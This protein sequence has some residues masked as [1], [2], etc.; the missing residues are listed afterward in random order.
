MFELI[1]GT[2][3]NI[4]FNNHI[5]ENFKNFF[6]V[7]NYVYNGAGVAVGDVNNDG[8]SDIYF[9]GNEVSNKLYLNQGDFNFE[10][11]SESAGVSGGEG[12]HN[13]VVMADVN[14]DG[15]QDIYVCR[16]GSNDSD[17][18][19]ANLLFVNQGDTTFKEQA[20]EYGLDDSGYSLMAS[21]FDMDNDNDLDLYVTNRPNTFFMGYQQVLQGK[22]KE[23]DLF[24]DKLYIN[25]NGKFKEV[26]KES[27]IKNN[28]GYGLGIAT[29]DLD[30][31]G[32]TD[33]MVSNDYL[34]RDYL[35][36]NQ[37]NGKFKDELP[38]HFNHV[39]FYAMGIDVV[40]FNND[41]FEDIMQLE[42]LPEDY[43]RSKT[44]MASMNMQLF[45]DMTE[46]GFHYQYMHNQLHLNQGNGIFSD[47]S[48]YSG[49]SKTDWSWA[50]L[51]SDF[52]NDGYRDLFITNGFKRDI[53]DKDAN[54][55]F[56]AYMRSPKSRGKT[57]EQK[58][59][60]II[61]LFKENKIPNYIYKNNGDL[62]FSKKIV[63][64]GMDHDSFSSGAATADFDNDG[65][66]DIA[67]NNIDGEAF[68]YRNT[69]EKLNNN[70]IKLKL[71]GPTK[72]PTGLGAKVTIKY[73]DTIQYHEFKT[74][75]GYLSSVEPTV[76]FGLGKTANIDEINV[77]WN[78]GKV[79]NISNIKVNQLLP[80]LYSDAQNEQN[81][82]PTKPPIFRDATA[83][84]F[85]SPF[86]H[87]ENEYDDFN[88]QILLP[89]KLSQ[90]GP[91]LAVGDLNNDGLEDFFVGG[92]SQQSGMIYTQSSTGQF[93][94]RNQ[95]AFKKDIA[96]EDVGALFFDADADKDLD[97]YVVSG[98]N[99]FDEHSPALQDRLYVNDGKG[100]FTTSN[101]LPKL[102][103]SGSCIV[104]M[105]FDSDGDLDLFVGGRL[106]PKKYPNAPKSFLLENDN[107]KFID[108]TETLAPELSQLGMVTSAVSSDID[109][110]GNK[111]LIIVGEWMPISIFKKENGIFKNVTD[112]YGLANTSGWWNKIVMS[113]IDNDGDIDFVIGNLGLNYKFKASEENPFLVYANDFDGNGTNDVFLA[114]SYENRE[115]PIRG[116]QCASQQ[117]PQIATKFKSFT[118]FAKADIKEVVS[119]NIDSGIAYKVQKFASIILENDQGVLNPKKLPLKAQFSVINGIVIDDFNKDGIQD[120]MIAGNKFEV[121]VETTRADASVGLVLSGSIT[122]EYNDLGYL[123][124]GF[125]APQNVKDIQ[126]IRLDNGRIGILT[127]I[128]DG[129]LKLFAQ[130]YHQ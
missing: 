57:N 29:S 123:Q 120:I 80:V 85:R 61:S 51:G 8:L 13:G 104:A 82:N 52:D 4:T 111:E 108:V 74:V 84:D 125:F 6:A 21:F 30:S 11:I 3:S 97:L 53:W 99:E 19:R 81:S 83:T 105:D 48:Q 86:V 103:E 39:P 17:T 124:S 26:G 40:D 112:D 37:G 27:G 15:F 118:D 69:S 58:A 66:L 113:D 16:G 44:T 54:T 24:R 68:I 56:N 116:W 2:E 96:S 102:L 73:N 7:F 101:G 119:E 77:V 76:H 127:A 100:N 70:H 41:G 106:V 49:V 5:E 63:E 14:G 46:N 36:M 50:C 34:E 42:M 115:V 128:N 122:G 10:D 32:L 43:E 129:E 126:K 93:I 121:E 109:N 87:E 23:D 130:G 117:M 110:D 18:D 67:V 90:N 28:F 59:Q 1:P 98:G 25:N 92:A 64:W 55:L 88:D 78:D 9:V 89:H 31:D 33:I 45:K 71:V 12:W 60:Y 62:T 20:A 35:Y 107:G 65:D 47:I 72:N 91:C 75:R 94:A 22:Q 114:K 95:S 79:T 38:Q